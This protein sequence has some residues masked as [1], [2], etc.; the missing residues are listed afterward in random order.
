M[1]FESL[2][3]IA[4]DPH[5]PYGY[6]E[7]KEDL[8]CLSKHYPSIHQEVIG[9]S[10]MGKPII[11]VRLGEGP[12]EV[13]YNG[14]IHANEWITS[15]LLMKF[16]AEYAQANLVPAEIAQAAPPGYFRGKNVQQLWHETCVW[17]VPMMNPDGVE[18]VVEGITPRHPFYKELLEWN[19]GSSQFTHWK[20]NIRGVDLN[21]QFPA[22][23]EEERSRRSEPGPGPCNYSGEGPLTEPEAKAIATFTHNRNFQ[24]TIALHTQGK[25]IYWNYRNLEPEAS[26][27]IAQKFAEVSGY[28]PVKLTESDAGYK[29]WFIQAFGRPGF[30]V[31]AGLGCNPLP[32]SQFHE[33]FEEVVNILLLGMEG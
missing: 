33:I 7:L 31:E 19:R 10:V 13:H 18:L 9:Q 11:A 17:V 6:K 23:W 2:D 4:S 16:V 27:F 12:R 24:L 8:M 15:A 5:Q 25:E 28:L 22:H 21:D 1:T 3:F 30:T 26:Q 32:L 14:A 20:A 29:D